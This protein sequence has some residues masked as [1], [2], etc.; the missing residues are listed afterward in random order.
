MGCHA[1]HPLARPA[2]AVQMMRGTEIVFAALFSVTFLKRALNRWHL[3]GIVLCLVGIS[4]VGVAGARAA[5]TESNEAAGAPSA[6][7]AT[8]GML[9][10]IAAEAVQSAQVVVEDHFMTGSLKFDPL[11]VVG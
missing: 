1:P 5:D 7:A 4:A 9:L 8:A 2:A 3:A 6:A 11:T 10:I